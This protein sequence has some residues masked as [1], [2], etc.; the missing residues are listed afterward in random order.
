MAL[1]GVWVDEKNTKEAL[2]DEGW[3]HTGDVAEVDDRGR[4]RIVDRIKV[5]L[6]LS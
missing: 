5:C 6:S 2:D 1:T 4:F 3:F